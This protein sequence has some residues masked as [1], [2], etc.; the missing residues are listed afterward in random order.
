MM[1]RKHR[2]RNALRRYLL[3]HLSPSEQQSVEIR[4]LRE[5]DLC[6]ELEFVEDELLDDYFLDEL[7]PKE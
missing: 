4:L 5:E 7:S 6:E 1:S 3:G 2:E